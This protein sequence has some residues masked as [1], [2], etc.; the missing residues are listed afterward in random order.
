MARPTRARDFRA[1]VDVAAHRA[2]AASAA[3]ANP[4]RLLALFPRPLS[5]LPVPLAGGV[6]ARSMLPVEAVRS[7]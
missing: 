3:G 6:P 2:A 1:A 4:A 5:S 7:S